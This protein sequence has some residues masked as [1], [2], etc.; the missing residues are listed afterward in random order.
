LKATKLVKIISFLILFNFLWMSFHPGNCNFFLTE[1]KEKI[2]VPL[3]LFSFPLLLNNDELI[4]N[5]IQ[6]NFKGNFSNEIMKIANSLGSGELQ[7]PL[8]G[9]LYLTRNEYNKNSASLGFKAWLRAGI[10]TWILKVSIGRARPCEKTKGFFGPGFKHLSFPSGHTSAAF[11][12]ATVMGERYQKK[13]LAYTLATLIGLSRIYFNKHYLSDVLVG[14]L[15]GYFCGKE[16]LAEKGKRVSSPKIFLG[17]KDGLN[18]LDKS[19]SSPSTWQVGIV[20]LF[21]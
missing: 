5:Q 2:L 10:Y 18:R 12:L 16:I 1:E 3:S 19:N 4:L 6:S 11:A 9:L 17:E 20:F 15:I 14:A 13:L 7:L 8:L 21:K